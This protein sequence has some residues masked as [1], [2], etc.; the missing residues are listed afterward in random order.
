MNLDL[1]K[2]LLV[3]ALAL[4]ALVLLATMHVWMV[5]KSALPQRRKKAPPVEERGSGGR[6]EPEP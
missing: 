3:G 6:C 5:P 4:C 1:I 2:M